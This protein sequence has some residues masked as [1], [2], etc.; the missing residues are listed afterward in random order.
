M[1]HIL[2]MCVYVYVYVYIYIHTYIHTHTHTYTSSS[3]LCQFLTPITNLHF[4]IHV[5]LISV[6]ISRA[7]VNMALIKY[8]PKIWHAL[9]E[10]IGSYKNYSRLFLT[11]VFQ[12]R[13]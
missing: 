2:R 9:C 11:G 3:F 13:V 4:L 12:L 5:L 10:T 8:H 7:Y 6:L 1:L